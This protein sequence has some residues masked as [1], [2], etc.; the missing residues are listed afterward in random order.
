[1]TSLVRVEQR[2]VAYVLASVANVVITIGATVG[3]VVGAHKGPIGVVVGNFTGT[4]CVYA[5]LLGYRR[6]QL[7]LE[8][9]RTLL[10]RMQGFGLPLV[11]AALAL[12]AINF[13]DRLFLIHIAGKSETGLYA[14]GVRVASAV[15]FMMIAFQ[16]AWPAFAYSIED[17]DEAKRA[18]A[19]VLTYVLFATCWLALA[20]GLL[21]PWIVHVLSSSPSFYPASRVVTLL[22]FS[23]AAYAGY[24]VVAIGIGRARRTQ[25]NWVVTGAAAV[26]NIVL[27][28]LLIPS[29]GMMGAAIA[30]VAAY[31]AMFAA[32]TWN[33]QRVFPVRYQWRRVAS[34]IGVSAGLAALGKAL[35]VG[36]PLAIL[37]ALGFPLA[38][39]PLGFYLPVERRRLR[40]LLPI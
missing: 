31:A 25:F 22:A 4:L 12:W 38:L 7:G 32:M 26:L 28:V 37:L 33:A 40:A 39:A 36:L 20:L 13:I 35:H 11:P 6:F 29:H 27:N 24:T 17:D 34:V 5:V 30:T 19:Y 21:S 14:L 8:F 18:Y 1:L 15:T 23:I 9:D 16:T 3:L 2:A 10:R